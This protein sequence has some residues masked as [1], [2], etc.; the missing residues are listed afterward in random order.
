MGR[1]SDAA[2]ICQQYLKKEKS[3][4]VLF[5]LGNAQVWA[6]QWD[7]AERTFQDAQALAK[8]RVEKELARKE[9]GKGM[10]AIEWSKANGTDPFYL[11]GVSRNATWTEINVAFAKKELVCIGNTFLPATESGVDK[12]PCNNLIQARA[13]VL[14]WQCR[15]GVCG[16][17][18][19]GWDEISTR[20]RIKMHV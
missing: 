11:L 9:H 15:L 3:L 14:E 16:G 7:G 10:R 12:V 13:F 18:T 2:A 17:K 19:V 20:K 5:V 6:K 1:Y 8:G 4:E